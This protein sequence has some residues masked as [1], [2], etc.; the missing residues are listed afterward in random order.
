LGLLWLYNPTIRVFMPENLKNLKHS[1]ISQGVGV[2][3]H[4]VKE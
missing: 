2:N 1:G 3:T 4:Q